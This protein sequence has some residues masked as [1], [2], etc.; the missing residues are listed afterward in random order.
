MNPRSKNNNGHGFGDGDDAAFE[1]LRAA[2]P[3]QNES[4]S[5]SQRQRAEEK[6][7]QILGEEDSGRDSGRDELARKREH[8]RARSPRPAWLAAAAC[9]G[10]LVLAGGLVI[11]G[12]NGTPEANAEVILAQAAESS[13]TQEKASDVGVTTRDYIAREDADGSGTV[14]TTFQVNAASELE[15]TV[16]TDGDI[17]QGSVLSQWAADPQPALSAAELAEIPDTALVSYVQSHFDDSTRGALSLLLA[18]GLSAPQQN[19]LYHFLASLDGNEVVESHTAELGGEDGVETIARAEDGLEFSVLPAT[20]QLVAV[21]GLMAP[22]V[23]TSVDAVA[24]LGC[25]NAVGLQGPE[26]ITLACG[27][28][29]H[30]VT[31]LQWQ[32][33]GADA[34]TASGVE[35]LNDCDPFCAEGT[36]HQTPVTVR[37]TDLED[38]GFN[39]RVYSR[40]EVIYPEGSGKDSESFPIGCAAV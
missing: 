39:A 5:E 25:V 21:K 6:L 13:L 31:E 19:Q 15:T 18:P 11:G 37:A 10:V 12:G 28:N 1:L 33:W 4:L 30:S 3:V 40:L 20:G 23:I 7:A 26:D 17:A 38:C 22:E 35:W 34:A 16:E 14:R 27:D 8:K 9:A 36:F 24:V 32:D 2:N 29:N